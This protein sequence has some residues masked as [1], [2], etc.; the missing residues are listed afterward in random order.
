MEIFKNTLCKQ[1]D[2]A[3][4]TIMSGIDETVVGPPAQYGGD[5]ESLN[6]EELFVAS[7]NS[8]I[9]LVFYHFANKYKQ[10]IRVYRSSAEG[11]VEK[12]RDGLRFT[13]VSVKAEV[14]IDESCDPKKIEE[15]TQLA[16]KYCLVSNSV[17]CPVEYSV[18]VLECDYN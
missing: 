8:C 4:T 3:A 2:S 14:E 18:K 6:P 13:S 11:V 5:S 16:E 9:M 10:V 1:A 15:I 7:I 12:T 17:A